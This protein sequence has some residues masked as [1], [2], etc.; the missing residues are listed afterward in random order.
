VSVAAVIGLALALALTLPAGSLADDLSS[1]AGNRSWYW[2]VAWQEVSASPVAGRGAG[3]FELAWLEEQPIPESILDAHSLYLETLAELGLVG[4]GLLALAL[5]PPLVAALRGAS[6]GAS[7]AAAGG[8]VAFL[9]HAGV[10]WDWEMPA[11]TVAGLL[12]GAAA[13]RDRAA[14]RS[15]RDA[16]LRG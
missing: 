12:C 11:V 5:A 3:T 10:D 13:L 2:H 4:L 1:R 9:F 8:Y 6:G 15:G 16:H 7:A 14:A